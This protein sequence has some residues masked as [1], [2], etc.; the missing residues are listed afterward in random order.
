M[1]FASLH[2]W[3]LGAK[4][5]SYPEYKIRIQPLFIDDYTVRPWLRG[6]VEAQAGNWLAA[7]RQYREAEARMKVLPCYITCGLPLH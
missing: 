1:R 2:P 3:V 7:L 5:V 6:M 4:H